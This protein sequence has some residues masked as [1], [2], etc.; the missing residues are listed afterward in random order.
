MVECGIL[1]GATA[2]R[3]M[4][5]EDLLD[6][7]V[8]FFYRI[9]SMINDCEHQSAVICCLLMLLAVVDCVYGGGPL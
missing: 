7:K 6:L 8:L 5:R 1:S 2:K 4:G 3:R 9:Q